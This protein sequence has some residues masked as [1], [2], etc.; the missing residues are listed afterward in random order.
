MPANVWQFNAQIVMPSKW[1]RALL[2]VASLTEAAGNAVLHSS[3]RSS[4]T[5][6]AELMPRGDINFD[7]FADFPDT[8]EPTPVGAGSDHGSGM[9]STAM[10]LPHDDATTAP[11]GLRH[12]PHHLRRDMASLLMAYEEDD[13]KPIEHIGKHRSDHVSPATSIMLTP[14]QDEVALHENTP[15]Q[16]LPK[17]WNVKPGPAI[18]HEPP[19]T[20]HHGQRRM[21]DSTTMRRDVPPKR[22]SHSATAVPSPTKRH[23]RRHADR[24]KKENQDG[25]IMEKQA[26]MS[27]GA[28]EDEMQVHRE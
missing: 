27:V 22:H 9:E 10:L 5:R 20:A 11:S 19:G 23:K 14:H 6:Q 17:T 21:F 24:H 25:T 1:L 16:K 4:A 18:I 13:E 15:E 8:A 3:T 2:F 26:M 7:D 28:T 12:G